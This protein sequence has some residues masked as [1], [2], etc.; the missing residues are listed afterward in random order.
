[1]KLLLAGTGALEEECKALVKS[2]HMETQIQ[3]W[4]ML[5]GWGN[6]IPCA[7]CLSHP[8]GLRGCRLM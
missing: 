2:L 6:S 4:G 7:M 5:T 1:M 3:F 8:A